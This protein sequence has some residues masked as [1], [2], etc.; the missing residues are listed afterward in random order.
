MTYEDI[1]KVLQERVDADDSRSSP[2]SIDK[3]KHYYSTPDVKTDEEL[4]SY[5]HVEHYGGEDC[6]STYYDVIHFVDHDVYV[7]VSG[8]WQSYEGL[9]YSYGKIFSCVRPVEKTTIVYQDI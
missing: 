5:K 4:G 9:D 7:K 8:H 3:F 6:G 2:D 1:E